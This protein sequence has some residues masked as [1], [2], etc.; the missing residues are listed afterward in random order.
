MCVWD[1]SIQ[2]SV[3]IHHSDRSSTHP[4]I[5]H[6]FRNPMIRKTPTFCLLQ[7][8]HSLYF[9]LKHGSVPQ[10]N[11][12][13]DTALH[14]SNPHTHT[15]KKRAA[16]RT[17]PHALTRRGTFQWRQK[18]REVEDIHCAMHKYIHPWVGTFQERVNLT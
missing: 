4:N 9:I 8:L 2:V 6:P 15:F 3:Q 14:L 18:Q 5:S 7:A 10:H 17:E 13:T 16:T 11:S 1:A 12:N